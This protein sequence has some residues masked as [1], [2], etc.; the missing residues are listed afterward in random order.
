VRSDLVA[1]LKKIGVSGTNLEKLL[2]TVDHKVLN[3][4]ADNFENIM[5]GKD[6]KNKGAYF[7]SII[8][9]LDGK[10]VD[11]DKEVKKVEKKDLS[12]LAS[13]FGLANTRIDKNIIKSFISSTKNLFRN[14]NEDELQEIWQ[15]SF[16]DELKR[17]DNPE[18]AERFA[19]SSVSKARQNSDKSRYQLERVLSFFNINDVVNKNNYGLL[20]NKC[21][22]MVDLI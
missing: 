15:Q 20:I 7:Y 10:A 14:N 2:T 18:L 6:I 12:V 9:K 21:L 17:T 5:F 19:N 3:Y 1:K 8:Q 11:L 22:N 4:Y 16:N 13:I